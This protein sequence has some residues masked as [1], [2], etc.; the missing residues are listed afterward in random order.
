MADPDL[1]A[2]D[3]VALVQKNYAF[4]G[5]AVIFGALLVDGEPDPS[6]QVKVP[7]STLNR[8]GLVKITRGVGIFTIKQTAAIP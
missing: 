8:H 3:H 5:A 6:A 2:A 1:A 4:E 7:L